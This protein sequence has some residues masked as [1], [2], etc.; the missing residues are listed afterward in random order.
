MI[1][2]DAVAAGKTAGLAKVTKHHKDLV[3]FFIGAIPPKTPVIVT[4]TF[5]QVLEVEDLSWKFFLP[6]SIM[7]RYMGDLNA[8]IQGESGDATKDEIIEKLKEIDEAVS[9]YYRETNFTEDLTIKIDSASPL[10]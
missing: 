6:N 7:P 9:C 10:S 8:Y 4:A 3:R 5:H 2:E 1:F